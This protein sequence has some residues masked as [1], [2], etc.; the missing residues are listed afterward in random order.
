MKA[1]TH[2]KYFPCDIT[3]SPRIQA[4]KLTGEDIAELLAD[5][6]GDSLPAAGQKKFSEWMSYAIGSYKGEEI[7]LGLRKISQIRRRLEHLRKHSYLLLTGFAKWEDIEGREFGSGSGLSNGLFN[8]DEITRCLLDD[9]GAKRNQLREDLL[10]L[11][12]AS[13]NALRRLPGLPHVLPRWAE[14]NFIHTMAIIFRDVL[15]GKPTKSN[16][17]AFAKFARRATKIAGLQKVGKDAIFKAVDTL[18]LRNVIRT[19]RK[20]GMSGS[21]AVYETIPVSFILPHVV[22]KTAD[23][24]DVIVTESDW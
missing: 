20:I 12:E 22:G 6:G 7:E 11:S 13:A 1:E 4:F 14:Q 23:G 2:G 9:C 10:K 8:L 18:N 21:R 15:S 19:D 5:A 16:T 24:K 17:S 3:Y